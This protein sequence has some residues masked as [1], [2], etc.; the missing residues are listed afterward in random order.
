MS[1]HDHL[2]VLQHLGDV[3]GTGARHLNPSFSKECTGRQ[4]KGQ[5]KD[6]MDRIANCI[7]QAVRRGDK[8]GESTCG[9]KLT[10]SSNGSHTPKRRT[11]KL[12]GNLEL[13]KLR[14]QINLGN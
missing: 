14:D 5:V 2:L 1:T 6:E 13:E 12:F 10:R 4:H 9:N 7:V 11:R 8:V 3:T